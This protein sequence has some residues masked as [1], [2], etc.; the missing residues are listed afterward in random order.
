MAAAATVIACRPEAQARVTVIA[1]TVG[2]EPGVESDLSADVRPHRRQNHAAPHHGVHLASRDGVP[3][4]QATHGGG[5]ESDA[6]ELE[7]FGEGFDERRPGAPTTTARRPLGTP[8]LRAGV[9]LNLLPVFF[10]FRRR[11]ARLRRPAARRP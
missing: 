11:S 6:V 4:E 10:P 9:D 7:V 2:S 3:I 8:A 1:S 5:A